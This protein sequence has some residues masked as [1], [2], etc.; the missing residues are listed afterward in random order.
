MVKHLKIKKRDDNN[1]NIKIYGL[2]KY[3]INAIRRILLSEIPITG[4]KEVIIEENTSRYINDDQVTHLIQSIPVIKS[5]PEGVT[6]SIDIDLEKEGTDL[7][8]G[9]NIG[10]EVTSNDIVSSDNKEYLHKDIPIIKLLANEKL[11]VKITPGI[12]MAK[13]DASIYGAIEVPTFKHIKDKKNKYNGEEMPVVEMNLTSIQNYTISDMLGM[14]FD[15]IKNKLEYIKEELLSE[16][17]IKKIKINVIND[18][19]I[20]EIEE[21]GD[22]MAKMIVGE[23]ISNRGISDNNYIGYIKKHPTLDTTIIKIKYL[24]EDPVEILLTTINKLLEVTNKVS[25]E[26]SF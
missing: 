1:I 19:Y 23:V 24:T 10:K 9:G 8:T 13:E 14:T 26:T 3:Y 20:F 6:F 17:E 18:L 5:V 22:T 16:S 11:K 21:I 7:S 12:G 2:H 25:K 15:I 4:L